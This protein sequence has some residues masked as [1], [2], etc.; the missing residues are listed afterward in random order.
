MEAERTAKQPRA[1]K[2]R[3]AAWRVANLTDESMLNEGNVKWKRISELWNAQKNNNINEIDESR[4][5]TTKMYVYVGFGFNR[6]ADI[7][8]EPTDKLINGRIHMWKYN[9]TRR[10]HH[11]MRL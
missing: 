1:V 10:E 4:A 11:E 6:S 8:A 2:P 7:V 9:N 3:L 5:R